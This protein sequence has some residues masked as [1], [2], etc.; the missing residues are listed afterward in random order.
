MYFHKTP[1]RTTKNSAR[2]SYPAFRHRKSHTTNQ[3]APTDGLP[4]IRSFGPEAEKVIRHWWS[5]VFYDPKLRGL[6]GSFQVKPPNSKYGLIYRYIVNGRVRYI[7]QTIKPLYWRMTRPWEG[8]NI[9]YPRPVK[10]NLLNAYR[11]GSL[12][13]ETEVVG[14]WRL[15]H[16]EKHLI[17][18]FATKEKLWNQEH[19]P[20]FNLTNYQN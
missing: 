2:K 7:G 8:G 11:S 4:Y 17:Q 10:R 9:G 20:Q 15:E 13:I 5:R 14:R 18:H 19:N 6:A 16:R 12:R 1:R 3:P